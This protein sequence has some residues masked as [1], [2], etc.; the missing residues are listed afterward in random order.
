MCHFP[1]QLLKESQFTK[2]FKRES[3]SSVVVE[4]VPCS[5]NNVFVDN[6]DSSGSVDNTRLSVKR[7]K[8]HK[9]VGSKSRTVVIADIEDSQVEESAVESG[10]KNI[11]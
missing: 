6:V 8:G 10:S 7:K 5:G 3:N 2:S 4:E 9:R 1:F 11:L